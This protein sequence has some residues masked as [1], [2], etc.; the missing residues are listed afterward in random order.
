MT[1]DQFIVNFFAELLA[2]LLDLLFGAQGLL[3]SSIETLLGGFDV[4]NILSGFLGG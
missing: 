4:S 2:S 1:L 3:S